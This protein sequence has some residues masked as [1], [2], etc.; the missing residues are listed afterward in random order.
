MRVKVEHLSCRIKSNNNDINKD[1][2]NVFVLVFLE[3]LSFNIDC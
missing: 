2:I 3:L 1:T